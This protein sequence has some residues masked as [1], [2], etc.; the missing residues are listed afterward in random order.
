[1]RG[2]VT[3]E[4]LMSVPRWLELRDVCMDL[5]YVDGIVSPSGKILGPEDLCLRP[6]HVRVEDECNNQ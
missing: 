2:G 6:R 5:L 1:M 3:W 4:I